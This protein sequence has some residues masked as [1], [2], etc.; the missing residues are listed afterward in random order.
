M[1]PQNQKGD[2]VVI[3]PNTDR[4]L[5]E[6]EI[7][8]LRDQ[9]TELIQKGRKKIILDLSSVTWVNSTGLNV[10]TDIM[11]E[12][13]SVGGD[14]KLSNLLDRVENL[15]IITKMISVIDCYDS[16]EEAVAAF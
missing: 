2:I 4:I 13:R 8:A 10:I 9:T 12:L 11:C 1:Y 5:G 15:L 16:V 7:K 14:L 3:S 6:P